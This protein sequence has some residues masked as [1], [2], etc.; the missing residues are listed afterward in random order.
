M[1]VDELMTR[2]VVSVSRE[3][4]LKDLAHVLLANDISGVP[5][6]ED[7]RLVGV[8]SES[9][10]VD[11]ERPSE[12]RRRVPRF[13]RR[14]TELTER[15]TVADA[16]TSPAFT[17]EWWMSVGAA[18]ARMVEHQVNRLPV[19]RDGRV[20]GIV[21]RADLV[22]AFGRA[23]EAIRR[24]IENEILPSLAPADQIN[25]DVHEG[26]VS[27]TFTAVEP[28]ADAIVRDVRSVAGVISVQFTEPAAA[29]SVSAET[30]TRSVTPS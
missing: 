25:V 5:V 21:A 22:R 24:E 10:I 12:R 30:A 13:G 15:R 9:D 20:V 6:V 4:P 28:D 1:R 2:D 23:D 11:L 17:I 16:M 26:E 7:G 29:A 3:T 19:V 27:L 8:I 14:T 18:A